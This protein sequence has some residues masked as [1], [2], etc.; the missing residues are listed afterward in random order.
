MYVL[1][2]NASADCWEP[3][4]YYDTNAEAIAASIEERKKEDG[5]TLMIQEESKDEKAER[6]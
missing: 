3:I 4:G 5:I 2:R 1:Y 6:G